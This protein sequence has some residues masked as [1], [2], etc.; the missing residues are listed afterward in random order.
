MENEVKDGGA[1]FPQ[2]APITAQI[3]TDI[4]LA[5]REI[6]RAEELLKKVT[7]ALNR[8]DTP[9]LRDAFGRRNDGL[10][11]GVPTSASGHTLF[12]VPW[13]VCKPIIELHIAHQRTKISVLTA[14]VADALLAAREGRDG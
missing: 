4:A 8:R 14:Q 7:E 12:N 10:Q 11:L 9:D 13:S 2:E 6:E 5:Y 3:A 1:A